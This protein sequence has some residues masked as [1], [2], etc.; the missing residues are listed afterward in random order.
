MIAIASGCSCL[1]SRRTSSPEP[2]GRS[3]SRNTAAGKWALKSL[4]ASATV[5][6]SI[7]EKPQLCRASLRVQRMAWSSS[8]TRISLVEFLGD[9][10][11]FSLTNSL[12]SDVIISLHRLGIK[13]NCTRIERRETS[14][15]ELY[16]FETGP[17]TI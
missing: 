10:L 1:I 3:M 9:M 17:A 16:R 11:H 13:Q 5:A 7:G 4:V 12:G 2:S 8:T 15:E 6:A 14:H